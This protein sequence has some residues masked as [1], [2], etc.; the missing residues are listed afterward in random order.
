MNMYKIRK[1][2]FD[3]HPILKNLELDFCDKNGNAVDT[4]I[5]AGENGCGKSTI[6]N[7]LYEIA[8]YSIE[9]PIIVEVEKEN[10]NYTLEFYYRNP[11]TSETLFVKDGTGLNAFIRATDPKNKHPFCGIFSDVDINFHSGVIS[12]VTSLTLDS[13]QNSR[14]STNDLP[15]Q[16][17]Q[18]LIDIQALD[19][20]FFSRRYKEAKEKGESVENLIVDERISRF[21]RAFDYMFDG[22]TYSHIDNRN[23]A[24]TIIFTKNDVEI[25]IENLSSGE[26]QIVYRGC[27]LLKDANAT[28]GAFAFIDE[29]EISLHPKWQMKIMDYYKGIFTNENGEQTSQIFAVT[30]SPFIIHNDN[31]KNDKVIVLARDENGDIIV[32]DKPEYFK[33][34]SIEAVQDAF[35]VSNF[36]AG[37]PTVYLEGRTDEKYFKKALEVFGY[38][39]PFQFQWVGHMKDDKSEEFTGEKS[40]NKAYQFLIGCNLPYKNV[41][42]FDCD[43]NREFNSNGN[44]CLFSIPKYTNSKNMQK[45]IENALVLDQIDLKPFYISNTKIGDYGENKS[46]EEFNKMGC[47]DYICSLDTETLKQVFS[48]LKAVIDRLI[49]IFEE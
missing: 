3:N 7:A 25:P 6:I 26:K 49:Q 31:R 20:A 44:A 23:G 41:C 43:T 24:K 28:N 14:R 10:K 38:A 12:N 18:L 39:V 33:C 35:S 4:V 1:V 5:F 40:L 42:L 22:L 46:N 11:E 15:T 30:H 19:D 27:F 37:Q 8:S 32:K 9:Y 36:T 21:K 2:K 48:N 13:T 47:C 29:P 34:N 17:N 45:G 16:I